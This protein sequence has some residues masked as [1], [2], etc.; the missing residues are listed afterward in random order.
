MQN[1]RASNVAAVKRAKRRQAQQ[2]GFL[3][4]APEAVVEENR[5]RLADETDTRDRLALSLERGLN[6][7]TLMKWRTK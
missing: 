1:G 5:Q 6:R 2:P 4:K 7:L 3:A